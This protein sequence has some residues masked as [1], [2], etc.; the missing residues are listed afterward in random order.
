MGQDF[1]VLLLVIVFAYASRLY[2]QI[3]SIIFEN[4]FIKFFRTLTSRYSS[5]FVRSAFLSLIA[6]RNQGMSYIALSFLN[7]GIIQSSQALGIVL[8]SYLGLVLALFVLNLNSPVFVFTLLIITFFMSLLS[9]KPRFHRIVRLSLYFTLIL[10]SYSLLIY[11]LNQ[12]SSEGYITMGL[13]LIRETPWFIILFSVVAFLFLKNSFAVL[14]LIYALNVS[15]ILSGLHAFAGAVALFVFGAIQFALKTH[16]SHRE[17]KLI[18]F[19]NLFVIMISSSLVLI[20]ANHKSLHFLSLLLIFCIL[21]AVFGALLGLNIQKLNQVFFPKSLNQN[22]R[23]VILYSSVYNYPTTLLIEFFYQEY[24]K[25]FVHVNTIFE[26]LIQNLVQKDRDVVTKLNK[27]FEISE[28][29][30]L[31]LR[32]L[33]IHMHEM[34]KTEK[35]AQFVYECE[36][37]LKSLNRFVES[38]RFFH[39]ISAQYSMT[40][41][42][43]RFLQKVYENSTF[44]LTEMIEKEEIKTVSLAL[45]LEEWDLFIKKLEEN[46]SPKDSHLRSEIQVQSMKMI[47]AIQTATQSC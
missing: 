31:E 37:R 3:I 18:S 32:R 26:M 41:F 13:S 34:E 16:K 11:V 14:G 35:Q 12:M 45:L 46:K 15:Q 1:L 38:I 36:S 17:T 25:L 6:F 42:H 43:I 21:I 2:S 47:E 22:T 4:L 8:G 7:S 10:A 5:S 29:V 44:I 39:D 33:Q 23:N 19:L 24:K 40:E 30:C 27:Y 9:D 20:F 28:K